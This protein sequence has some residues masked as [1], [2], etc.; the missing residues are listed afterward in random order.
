MLGAQP[1]RKG[2]ELVEV[3]LVFAGASMLSVLELVAERP[4]PTE[5]QPVPEA[6]KFVEAERERPGPR[7]LCD[8]AVALAE[9]G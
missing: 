8:A 7:E 4:D 6:K 3:G 1:L 2:V 5:G 9:R